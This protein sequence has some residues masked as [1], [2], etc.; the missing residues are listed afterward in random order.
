MN[1]EVFTVGET[2][3]SI[4]I[5]LVKIKVS[6]LRVLMGLTN[7]RPFKKMLLLFF[8]FFLTLTVKKFQGV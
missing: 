8:F 4:L 3:R 1:S 7:R 2:S 6:R 5:S